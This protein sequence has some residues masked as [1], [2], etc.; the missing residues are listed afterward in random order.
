MSNTDTPGTYAPH[1]Y[2]EFKCI[3]DKCRHSCCLDWEICIDDATYEKYKDIN[4]ISSTIV[5]GDDGPCFKLCADGRCPHLNQNGL[6]KI[7][8]A[9]GEGYLSDICKNHPRFY[10]DAGNG[11]TE[12]GL[13][14]VCEEACRL[15]LEDDK[16]FEL[17]KIDDNFDAE[18][19]AWGFDPIPERDRIISIT[20]NVSFSFDEKLDILKT[21]YCIP[22]LGTPEEWTKR[23]LN[24]EILYPDWERDLRSMQGRAHKINREDTA[25]YGK[26]Y[27]RLL[28]YFVYR[29]VGIADCEV[30]LSARLAFAVLSTELIRYLFEA[31]ADLKDNKEG[32]PESLID[33]ARRYSAEIEYSD[34]NADDIIFAFEDAILNE[35]G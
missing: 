17:I 25:L 9:H 20:E 8:L 24:L 27:E 19:E 14:I 21:E 22:D 16:P 1:Y 23:I 5:Q 33:W 2:T 3:A 4:E 32:A 28:K 6:C 29:H 7:I 18:Y 12:A 26:Y 34:E 31:N 11:R 10:N 13:G 30:N 35:K 15:I